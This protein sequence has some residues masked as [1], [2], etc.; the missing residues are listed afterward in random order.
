MKDRPPFSLGLMA[1]AVCL[2]LLALTIR[3][4][5]YRWILFLPTASIYCYLAFRTTTGD[6]AGDI[7]LGNGLMS[8]LLFAVDYILL[9]DVQTELRL[10]G[11]TS[12]ISSLGFFDR[13]W[14]AVRLFLTP[15]GIG[16]MHASSSLR[17]PK[18]PSSRM[19]FVCA[20]L[21]KAFTYILLERFI[22]VVNHF[23]PALQDTEARSAR[24]YGVYYQ[25]LAV[26]GY[27]LTLFSGVNVVFCMT[28][29]LSVL[30]GLSESKDWPDVFGDIRDAYSV[31]RFWR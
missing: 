10:K 6:A 13:L 24:H 17:S 20:K 12:S 5:P 29:S 4:S 25:T 18:N 16:W 26:L 27:A 9:T 30:F 28:S 11:Q 21:L 3:P 23:N 15:R 8:L 19:G 7:G 31:Q 2:N 14:W 1:L 22:S